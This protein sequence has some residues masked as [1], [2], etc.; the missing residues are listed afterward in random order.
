[1]KKNYPIEFGEYLRQLRTIRGKKQR[2]VSREMKELYPN[3]KDQQLYCIC[4]SQLSKYER[5]EQIPAP[6]VLKAL[7]TIYHE[8]YGFMLYKAGY[9]E[10]N[11]LVPPKDWGLEMLR[12]MHFEKI[13]ILNQLRSLTEDERKNIEQTLEVLITM[14]VAKKK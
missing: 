1:M 8:S 14:T 5:G 9:L 4:D 10:D 3:P 13:C 11:P 12:N 2:N 6:M 7:S